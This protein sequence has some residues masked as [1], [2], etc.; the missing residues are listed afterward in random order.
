MS[1]MN[2]HR[3][4]QW[5]SALG[6]DD[7]LRSVE[8]ALAARGR[9]QN[10]V[11]IFMS[12]NGLGLGAHRWATKYCEYT[13]CAAVPLMVRYPGQHGRQDQRLVTNIDLAPTFAAIAGTHMPSG[14]DGANLVPLFT[15]PSGSRSVRSGILEHWPGGDGE[16]L[17]G[18]NPYSVPAFYGIRTTGWRYVE[19]ASGEK[20]LYNE[21]AD[22]Y[23]LQNRAGN[24]SY[25]TVQSQLAA[26][27]HQ[28]EAASGVKPGLPKGAAVV[29][30]PSGPLIDND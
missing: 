6:V 24:P 19:L 3:L 30:P 16:H 10:A 28:L 8:Q 2:S 23:E 12:D 13:E 15:D 20:E 21:S 11:V 26:Q 5:R 4:Q 22:P 25:A 1:L 27:L 29:A 9:L 17:N 14:V 7:M 18:D